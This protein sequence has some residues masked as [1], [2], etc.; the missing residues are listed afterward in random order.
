MGTDGSWQTATGGVLHSA[1]Y[2]GETFDANIKAA[3]WGPVK[4]ADYGYGNLAPQE[5]EP[6]KAE[7]T[8]DAKEL[9]V[10]PKGELVIDFG[11]NL[12]G[13][14]VISFSGKPGQKITISHA[15]VLDTNLRSAKAQSCYICDGTPR[16]YTTRFT[17]YG[18][19][20]I[21]IEGIPQEEIALADFKAQ[22]RFSD[23]E[24]TGRFSCSDPL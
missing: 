23:M 17:F 19:R 6:V 21:K 15:E 13:S 2:D 9:I 22:V 11:Q 16:K 24:P 14:E 7:Q 18:F 12:V 1:I 20:Y 5:N 3:E 8:V 4:V 10:T